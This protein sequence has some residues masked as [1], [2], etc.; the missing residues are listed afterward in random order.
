[1]KRSIEQL[2]NEG[3]SNIEIY[4]NLIKENQT[5]ANP[6]IHNPDNIHDIAENQEGKSLDQL[7]GEGQISGQEAPDGVRGKRAEHIVIG[8]EHATS[9]T[10]EEIMKPVNFKEGCFGIRSD[11]EL[12]K[13]KVK[14][15]M[16][17]PELVGLPYSNMPL[18][19]KHEMIFN[20]EN[21]YRHL[22]SARMRIGKA[23]QAFDGG[24]SVYPR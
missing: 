8:D 11:I 7:A 24:K 15:W 18:N 14:N 16:S 17:H 9:Q 3:K 13:S 4:E 10:E 21:A 19:Q 12:V 5:M 6:N 2:K 1:M 20:L 22:E 23:I